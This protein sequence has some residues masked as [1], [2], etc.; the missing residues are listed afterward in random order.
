M[1]IL[2]LVYIAHGWSLAIGDHPL[3]RNEIEAWEYGPVIRSLYDAVKHYGRDPISAPLKVVCVDPA[4]NEAREEEPVE[5]FTDEEQTIL[6]RVVEVYGP[7]RAYQLSALT[8]KDGTPWSKVY[9]ERHS[10][11][12]DSEIAEH[13]RQLAQE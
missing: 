10:T 1:H 3:I 5:A 12:S 6:D 2:K 7:L 8:H 4:T 11:I 13:F 9:A